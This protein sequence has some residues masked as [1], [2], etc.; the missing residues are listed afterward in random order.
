MQKE[1]ELYVE[2]RVVRVIGVRC[3]CMDLLMWVCD[4]GER[5][6]GV[7]F[8]TSERKRAPQSR[9]ARRAS[10]RSPS[11]RIAPARVARA[12]GARRHRLDLLV[13]A[14]PSLPHVATDAGVP[15]VA[16]YPAARFVQSDLASTYGARQASLDSVFLA[17]FIP[18]LQFEVS[19]DGWRAA[20]RERDSVVKFEIGQKLF[21]KLQLTNELHL[22]ARGISSGWPNGLRPARN[23]DCLIDRRLRDGGIDWQVLSE[24]SRGEHQEQDQQVDCSHFAEFAFGLPAS[25]ALRL[26]FAASSAPAFGPIPLPK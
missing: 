4:C 3:Y 23:A 22:D 13:R 9:Q 19:R 14:S 18:R 12:T 17:G 24:R 10:C 26:A 8:A 25:I 20:K 2:A 7:P 5:G 6:G 16:P 1:V 11:S 21:G 15:P